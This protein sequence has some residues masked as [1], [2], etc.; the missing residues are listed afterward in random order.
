MEE[1]IKRVKKNIQRSLVSLFLIFFA[2]IP[3]AFA[4]DLSISPASGLY[5]QGENFTVGIYVSSEDQ[6]L[7]A[8][9]GVLNFPTNKLQV[10]SISK[11]DSIIN[12]WA[13]EPTFSNTTGRVSFEGVVLTPGFMGKSGKALAVT[14]KGTNAGIADLKINSG[15]ILANDGLGTSILRN[16][17]DARFTITEIPNKPA[18]EII[19]LEELKP[20][21]KEIPV[22]DN[23]DICKENFVIT[24]ATHPGVVWRKE[25]N[26]NF[27]WIIDESILASKIA[28]DQNPNTEP[29]LINNPAIV[30]KRYENVSDGVW[31]F[32]L[33]LQDN[34]GWRKTEHFEIK[35]DST[36]P[37]ITMSEIKRADLTDPRPIIN[38]N[39]KD[40]LSCIKNFELLV[41]GKITTYTKL[42][43]GNIKLNALTPGQHDLSIIVYDRASNKNQA[44]LDLEIK[45]LDEPKVV[46]YKKE[47]KQGEDLFVEGESIKN[48]T[49]EAQI[50]N[51]KGSLL[52]KQTIQTGGGNFTLSQS[53][54]K[55]GVIFVSFRVKDTRGALSNWSKPISIEIRGTSLSDSFE[56]ASLTQIGIISLVVITLLTAIVLITRALT[57]RR[58]RKNLDL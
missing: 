57:I 12:F 30:E 10:V 44:F 55:K 21:D 34:T 40:N 4:A 3:N 33:A 50:T 53:G 2:F 35:V 6:A 51:K 24:S 37:E 17:K 27:S 54:L 39:I 46:S 15:S 26:A 18:P 49:I 58:I 1:T 19:K 31:Y 20:L 52:I 13:K 7:N 28:F 41:D 22:V 23:S 11:S 32:H 42:E 56:S 14:F 9:S 8:L 16:I 25:N 38:L 43:N 47:I 29:S 5:K 45:A 48:G 36:P